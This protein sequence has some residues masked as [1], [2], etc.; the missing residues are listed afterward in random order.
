MSLKN[1]LYINLEKRPDRKLHVEKQLASID[2]QG[3][4]FNACEMENGAIGCSISHLK[5]LEMAKQNDWNQVMI[6]EDDITFLDPPLLKHKLYT[7]LD[8]HQD[9]DVLLLGGNNISPYK[10]IDDCCIKVSHCQTTTGYIV[11]KHYYN[12]LIDNIKMGLNYLLREPTKHFYYAIDKYW[13]ALQKTDNWYLLVPLSVIQ[14]PGYSDIEKRDTNY[15]KMLT[16]VNK[17]P[18]YPSP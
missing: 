15:V 4:R 18:L 8:R 16:S 2:L 1:I 5:C 6:V 11:K 12:K 17:R 3:T 10:V 9:W 13:L 7:F 14:Q